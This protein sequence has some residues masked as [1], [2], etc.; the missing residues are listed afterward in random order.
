MSSK[1]NIWIFIFVAL[2]IGG[3]IWAIDEKTKRQVAENKLKQK[4]DDYLKLLASYLERTKDIPDE[5]KKQL[6]HLRDKYVGVHDDVAI[7]LKSI[8][9]LIESKKEEIAI[10]K[11]TKIIENLLK[12]KFVEEGQAKDKRSCPKLFK[13]LEKALELKWISKHEFYV[14]NF[15]KDKRNDEAHELAVRFPVNW[16]FIAFLAGIEILY[17]LKGIKRT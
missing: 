2:A 9:E 6:Y 12:E 16:K 7:E 8:I 17:N 10:E 4:E 3:F 1:K 15:L 11:L 5:I 14:S 13:L